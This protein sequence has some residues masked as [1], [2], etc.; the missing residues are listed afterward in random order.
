M[1]KH[2]LKTLPYVCSLLLSPPIFGYFSSLNLSLM[3]THFSLPLFWYQRRLTSLSNILFCLVLYQLG[4][5]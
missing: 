1:N 2:L 5:H 4:S 3:P